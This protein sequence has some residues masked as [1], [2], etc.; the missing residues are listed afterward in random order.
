MF[1]A[2]PMYDRPENAAAHD[3]LWALIRDALR[4]RAIPAPDALDRATHHVEGWAR[5]DLTLSMI[6]NLPYRARFRDR[7]TPIAAADFGLPETAPGYYHSVFVVRADD[8]AKNIADTNGYRFAFNEPL[9]QSGWG[10]PSTHARALGLALSPALQTGGHA[11]SLAAVASGQADLAAVDAVTFRNLSRWDPVARDVRVIGRTH[12]TPGMTFITA[13]GRD[14]APFHAALTAALAAL[15]PDHRDT[16]GM[17]GIV[18]L[19]PSAY[20]IPL[21]AP[22]EM[23]EN[24]TS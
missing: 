16:L 14:P 20:D 24:A 18:A 15:T 17:R 3:A 6:C 5:P 22:P 1:A 23:S 4:A 8:P 9:S 13:P 10:A 21:P 11:R 2:L 19:P 12:T 7:V